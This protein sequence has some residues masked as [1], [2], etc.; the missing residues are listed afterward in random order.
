MLFQPLLGT[1]TIRDL[2]CF[3]RGY[4]T[5]MLGW[6]DSRGNGEWVA[7]IRCTEVQKRQLRIFSGAGI[8]D[9]S[10]PQ[11]ELEEMDAKMA[12][13]LKATDVELNVQLIA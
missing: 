13:I 4:F 8:V 9:Q 6:C 11:S 3:E 5:G 12:T 1:K 7:T 10:I 2:E